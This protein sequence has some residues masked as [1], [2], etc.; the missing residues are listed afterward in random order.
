MTLLSTVA[1]AVVGFAIVA[2]YVQYFVHVKLNSTLKS[3]P[4]VHEYIRKTD[5][6]TKYVS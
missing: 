2:V 3:T 5:R 6:E 4:S 1:V